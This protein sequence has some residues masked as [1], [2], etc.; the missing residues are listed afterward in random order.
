MANR[1]K[2]APADSV[3]EK[4]ESSAKKTASGRKTHGEALAVVLACLGIITLLSLVSYDARDTSLNASGRAAVSNWIGPAGAYWADLMLQL[5]GIG[6]YALGLGC[7]LAGWRALV[8]R[9]VRPGARETIGVALLVV[10]SGTLAHLVLASVQR[11]Y[12]AGGVAGALLGHYLRT[13]FAMLGAYIMAGT[14]VLLS[15]ALTADGI[16]HGLGMRGASAAGEAASHV[17]SWWA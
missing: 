10:S 12:P 7:V 14:F 17:K 9:R 11:S 15:L 2:K 16:L 4:K 5:V 6:A 8:G 3:S 13:H 1:R